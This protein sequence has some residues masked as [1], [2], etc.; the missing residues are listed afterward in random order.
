MFPRTTSH[1]MASV[2]HPKD[3]SLPWKKM[4]T[5]RLPFWPQKDLFGLKI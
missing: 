1:Q 2:T 5:Q 3:N 4:L